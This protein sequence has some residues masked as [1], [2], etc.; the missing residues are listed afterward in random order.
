M[1]LVT[2]LQ[3]ILPSVGISL[4]LVLLCLY[5]Y[6]KKIRATSGTRPPENPP[7]IWTIPWLEHREEDDVGHDRLPPPYS[8]VDQPPPYSLFD[9]KGTGVRPL[10]P[11]PA[12]EMYPIPLPLDSPHWTPTTRS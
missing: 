6:A 7:S 2:F 10:S 9:P 8:T 3:Y 1:I 12:Y 4:A 5:L 11:P